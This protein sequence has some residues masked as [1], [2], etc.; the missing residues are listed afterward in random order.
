MNILNNNKAL[1]KILLIIILLYPWL[2]HVFQGLYIP[3]LGYW[4]VSYENFFSNP[5]VSQVTFYSWLTTFL[6]AIVDYFIGSLGVVGFKAA[7][8]FVLYLILYSVYKLL[9]TFTSKLYLLY[10]LLIAEIMVNSYQFI[11]YYH[12]TTLFFIVASLFL[13]KGLTH[14]KL[15]YLFLSGIFLALNIFIR[16]PNILGIG[17]IVAIIYYQYGK[18]NINYKNML[19]QIG[20]LLLA[21]IITIISVLIFMK[22]LGHYDFYIQRIIELFNVTGDETTY[23]K[24]NLV[25]GYLISQF[26][27]VMLFLILFIFSFFLLFILK[28][29]IKNFKLNFLRF[30]ILISITVYILMILSQTGH[31]NYLS[32]YPGIIGYTYVL[33]IYIAFQE[34]RKN[35]SFGLIALLSFF[36]IEVTPF[37]SATMLGKAEFGIYLAIPVIFTYL[38][39]RKKLTLKHLSFEETQIKSLGGIIGL[40]LMVHALISITIYYPPGLDVR[41]WA[42][43][44][45]VDD[46]HLRANFISGN[47]AKTLNDLI[48][49]MNNYSKNFSYILTYGKIST[50][51]YLSNLKPYINNTYP[52][53]MTKDKLQD[54]LE[55]QKTRKSLPMVVRS[56]SMPTTRGWPTITFPITPKDHQHG[57]IFEVF[58]KKYNYKSVWKNRDF[59]ILIPNQKAK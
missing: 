40:A 14:N 7:N 5:E 47:K 53:F 21:Y 19:H 32:L 24:S 55:Y 33:L 26:S 30:F 52:G 17:F 45:S 6:G 50:V 35:T 48:S 44:H 8:V 1:E 46:P 51:S 12:L 2:F 58:L 34:F 25:F 28:T 27:A 37:G 9:Y 54:E 22:V 49:A 29:Q 23:S 41:R 20:I 18:N 57:I 36:I 43:V 3:E 42:W 10:F 13:Y 59:E 11:N 16:F 56:I 39:E 38:F 31:T 4:L 15:F